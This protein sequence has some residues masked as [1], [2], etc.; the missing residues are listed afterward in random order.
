MSEAAPEGS[1]GEMLSRAQILLRQAKKDQV[2]RHKQ[3]EAKKQAEAGRLFIEVAERVR[4]VE[5]RRE[6]VASAAVCFARAKRLCRDVLREKPE[7]ECPSE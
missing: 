7:A 2:F 4:S 6:H 3:A 1:L 5:A